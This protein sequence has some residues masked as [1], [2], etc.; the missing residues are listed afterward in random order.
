MDQVRV[1][2]EEGDQLQG[3]AVVQRRDEGSQGER[4]DAWVEG[5]GGPG[6]HPFFW[7]ECLVD[8]GTVEDG[9]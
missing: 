3:R 4:S 8:A 6:Q 2:V 5:G 9:A 1:S 7:L